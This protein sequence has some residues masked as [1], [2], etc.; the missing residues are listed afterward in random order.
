MMFPWLGLYSSP[1]KGSES[2]LIYRVALLMSQ[3]LS[4]SQLPSSYLAEIAACKE[5]VQVSSVS[6]EGLQKGGM[7]VPCERCRGELLQE[8]AGEGSKPAHLPGRAGHFPSTAVPVPHVRIC[9]IGSSPLP[10]VLNKYFSKISLNSLMLC[11]ALLEL[12]ES[13]EQDC[14]MAGTAARPAPSPQILHLPP[15]KQ[16][17][18]PTLA[19]SCP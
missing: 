12:K 3:D 2:T 17:V 8:T 16:Q 5:R 14:C 6:R 11:I 4:L 15:R 1:L 18:P 7:K 19:V 9:V 13:T 10:L